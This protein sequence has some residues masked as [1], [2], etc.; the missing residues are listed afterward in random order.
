[1]ELVLDCVQACGNTQLGGAAGALALVPAAALGSNQ[2]S[3]EWILSWSW[4]QPE[5][6]TKRAL[7]RSAW[8]VVGY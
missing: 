7:T 2:A 3:L 8:N 5:T 1:M 6:T 4:S